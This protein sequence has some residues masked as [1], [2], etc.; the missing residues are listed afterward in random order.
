MSI[1][2]LANIPPLISIITINK[3]NAAGLAKTIKSIASQTYSSI[4]YIVVDGNSSDDSIDVINRNEGVI[5]CSI[6]ENDHGIYDA[7]NK[8]IAS[9]NGVYYLFLNSGDYLT[10]SKVI[11]SM[12][13]MQSLDAKFIYGNLVKGFA[14]KYEVHKGFQ[15]GPI[16]LR[17]FE[18]GSLAHPATFIHHSIFEK[19]GLYDTQLKIVADWKLFLIAVGINNES[20][21]YRDVNVSYF[22]MY[23][24]SNSSKTL[25]DHERS[26][27]WNELVGYSFKDK[28]ITD[29]WN[30]CA[31][32][33]K[34]VCLISIKDES[35]IIE[36]QLQSVET[37][38]DYII[39]LD[40][41]SAGKIADIA[42]KFEKVILVRSEANELDEIDSQ[43]RLL[44]EAR[45]IGLGNI[46]VALNADES[47]SDN[48]IRS[49]DWQQ[50]KSARSGTSLAF[51][52]INLISKKEKY[53]QSDNHSVVGWVDDGS[54]YER[55]RK[56]SNRLP[57]RADSNT[58]YLTDICVLNYELYQP[59]KVYSKRRFELMSERLANP[60]GC[61]IVLLREYQTKSVPDHSTLTDLDATLIPSM[62]DQFDP[63]VNSNCIWD[64]MAASLIK[65]RD[66]N[67]F[68]ELPIWDVEFKI[69]ETGID[70]NI[71]K[72]NI[73]PRTT[74]QKLLH[75][76]VKYSHNYRQNVCVKKSDRIIS[77]ALKKAAPANS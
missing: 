64:S 72:K 29:V 31:S 50:I 51:K 13:M 3:N 1:K 34:V 76:W 35:W 65:K 40:Q 56:N 71:S 20:V 19:Y 55:P 22:D 11:E 63:P 59:G 61:L 33:K 10:G 57:Y 36:R 62:F 70:S 8:G 24:V 18:N 27:V 9:A 23:G 38:A 54:G 75:A 5:S 60:S 46:L 49:D 43:K 32:D 7:M 66:V 67:Y 16:T 12:F 48:A 2:S 47:L 74:K 58:L 21:I 25:V 15:N 77:L 6:I 44:S 37:W 41:T 4:E 73:D 14:D 53:W 42:R 68:S 69:I 28:V 30:M 45:Q 26:L 39:L 17:D 52:R